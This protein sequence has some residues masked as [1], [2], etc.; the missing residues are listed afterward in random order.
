MIGDDALRFVR[1]E[2]RMFAAPRAATERPS[3]RLKVIQES[4]WGC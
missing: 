4:R 2:E 1:A 3:C